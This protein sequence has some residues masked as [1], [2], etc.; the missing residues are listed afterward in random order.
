[1]PT[2]P[3]IFSPNG[4]LAESDLSDLVELDREQKAGLVL[5]QAPGELDSQGRGHPGTSFILVRMV[6]APSTSR[7]ERHPDRTH[8]REHYQQEEILEHRL[9]VSRGGSVL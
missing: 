2:V 5:G 3:M 6:H 9:A 1:M 8:R 4:G 7:P